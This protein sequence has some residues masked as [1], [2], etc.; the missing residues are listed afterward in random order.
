MK[1]HSHK[2][3]LRSLFA[4]TCLL[5]LQGQ[6]RLFAQWS[7]NTAVNNAICNAADLQDIPLITTDGAGGAIITWYDMR[8]GTDFN[9]YAQRI[10]AAGVVQ[11]TTD[12]E[13][14]CNAALA[15][16]QPQIVSDGAG[17]AIISWV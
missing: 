2:P 12:G 6:A 14:I 7:T 1:Q 16:T 8:N 10:D 13:V 4:F 17:G 5:L 9:I 11:W 15:Q 3:I